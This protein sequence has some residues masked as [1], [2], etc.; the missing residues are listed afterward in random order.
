MRS[1]EPFRAKLLS[2]FIYKDVPLFSIADKCTGFVTADDRRSRDSI[3]ISWSRITI[4]ALK[5]GTDRTIKKMHMMIE[6]VQALFN[7]VIIQ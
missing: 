1:F 2:F 7:F 6:H 4:M 3:G 5:M